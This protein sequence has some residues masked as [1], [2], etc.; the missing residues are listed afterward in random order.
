MGQCKEDGTKMD[1]RERTRGKRHK[2]KQ[3]KFHLN[4]KKN[5]FFPTVKVLEQAVQRG[6]WNCC[7]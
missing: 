7:P 1:P 5:P 4:T 6:V 2:L 3:R